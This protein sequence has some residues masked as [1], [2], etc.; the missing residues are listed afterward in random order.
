MALSDGMK[1]LRVLAITGVIG[2]AVGMVSRLAIVGTHPPV[3]VFVTL[4]GKLAVMCVVLGV[5]MVSSGFFAYT[6]KNV[7]LKITLGMLLLSGGLAWYIP[8][9]H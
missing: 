3:Q 8:L 2:L 7:A 6:T 5:Y 1:L 9:G 4:P